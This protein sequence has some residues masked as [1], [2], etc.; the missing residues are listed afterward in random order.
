MTQQARDDILDR[1]LT[2]PSF[3]ALLARDP[4]KA[5]ADYDLTPEE[6]AAFASGTARAEKLEERMSKSDLAA[7]ISI[8]TSS[9]LLKAPSQAAKKR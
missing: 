8:K 3:R 1:A 2:D 9:P 7:G 5:L 4:A 6:R